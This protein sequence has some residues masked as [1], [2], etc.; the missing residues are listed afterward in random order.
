M[1]HTAIIKQSSYRHNAHT[2]LCCFYIFNVSNKKHK[3]HVIWIYRDPWS[4]I[5]GIP[6]SPYWSSCGCRH[7]HFTSFCFCF[8]L[9]LAY[10]RITIKF[11]PNYEQETQNRLKFS[12]LLLHFCGI[13]LARLLWNE[14]DSVNGSFKVDFTIWFCLILE[15]IIWW[16]CCNGPTEPVNQFHRIFRTRNHRWHWKQKRN[17]DTRNFRE[18][19]QPCGSIT[20]TRYCFNKNKFLCF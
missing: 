5:H 12:S 19:V 16:A 1:R 11:S 10:N 2:I 17:F 4:N 20:S 3:T 14:M 13:Y 6:F 15:Y 7:R 18:S 9:E 8:G